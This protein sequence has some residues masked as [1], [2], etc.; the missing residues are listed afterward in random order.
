MLNIHRLGQL[1]TRLRR[2]KVDIARLIEERDK[3]VHEL[4]LH[5]PRKPD[6]PRDVIDV[7]G[8]LR[9]LQDRFYTAI[10]LPRLL[11]S[12]SSHGSVSGKSIKTNA[13]PHAQSCFVFKA[14]I[15]NFYPSILAERVRVHF[16]KDLGCRASVS[17][18]L[19]RL[20]TYDGHL[21]LG[22]V[23]SPILADSI[24]RPVDVRI[25][26]ACAKLGLVFTRYV[27]DITISGQFD[28]RESGIPSLLDNVLKSHG[29]KA[30]P[31]KHDFGRIEDTSI[32]GVR[33]RN[34]HL[35]VAQEY[36]A[37]LA[38][39]L[40]DA[41]SLARKEFFDGPFFTE[42]QIRG[43]VTYVAWVNPGRR[44][45]LAKH[46]AAI[47]WSAHRA[48]AARRGLVAAKK[49]LVRRELASV[50]QLARSQS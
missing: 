38:R 34:G 15:S 49:K 11:A 22:L 27:D 35:D 23:T 25:A 5:D 26:T 21:A 13:L 37:E 17:E 44:R 50:E 47:D 41:A 31:D 42:N 9:E 32:T 20:C 36:A 46:L 48:E 19:A 39:Q 10:L 43:R 40:E 4:V 8:P 30:N 33:V 45:A 28:L 7:R 2:S 1:T 16:L 24:L 6:K 12:E 18:S 14:D 3:Y 29:F